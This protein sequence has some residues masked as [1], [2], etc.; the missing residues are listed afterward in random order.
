MF[1]IHYLHDRQV[2]LFTIRFCGS[3]VATE[4]VF[5]YFL[6]ELNSSLSQKT[7]NST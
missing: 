6:R 1:A 5:I 4:C 3:P 2:F 7:A